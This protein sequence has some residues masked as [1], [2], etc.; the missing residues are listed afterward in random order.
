[1]IFSLREITHCA[2][3]DDQARGLCASYCCKEAVFKTIRQPFNGPECEL[4]WQ[5]DVEEYPIT[6][7]GRLRGEYAVSGGLARV[8]MKKSGECLV[9]AYLFNAGD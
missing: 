2:A 5:P 1:M 3:L 6:L 4:F 9:Q 8:T 7:S